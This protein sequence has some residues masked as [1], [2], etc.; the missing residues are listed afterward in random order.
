[1]GRERRRE[2]KSTATTKDFVFFV[3]NNIIARIETVAD[4]VECHCHRHRRQSCSQC[5]ECQRLPFVFFAFC[6][7][8]DFDSFFLF[9]RVFLLLSSL[10]LVSC[11][12]ASA[13]CVPFW[14]VWLTLEAIES[15]CKSHSIYS[16]DDDCGQHIER[17]KCLTIYYVDIKSSRSRPMI[18]STIG[19]VIDHLE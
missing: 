5:C 14:F 3:V 2:K 19:N 12:C 6:R 17:W 15:V 9:V 18:Y 13:M 8:P 16:T 7:R 1:M 4:A 11:V 10:C